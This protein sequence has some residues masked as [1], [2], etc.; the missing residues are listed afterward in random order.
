MESSSKEG[1]PRK[2]RTSQDLVAKKRVG[3]GAKKKSRKGATVASMCKGKKIPEKAV[4]SKSDLGRKHGGMLL[5]VSGQTLV[6][7]SCG[8]KFYRTDKQGRMFDKYGKRIYPEGEVQM[9]E[10]SSEEEETELGVEKLPEN[11]SED[12][13]TPAKGRQRM[14]KQGEGENI[15]E[16]TPGAMREGGDGDGDSG[17]NGDGDDE[18][19]EDDEDVSESEIQVLQAKHEV[20]ELCRQQE[21]AERCTAE[22]LK[23][24]QATKKG[25]R[26]P[27]PKR[28]T[29]K[30][31]KTKKTSKT[32]QRGKKVIA[33]KVPRAPARLMPSTS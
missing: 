20:A 3:G 13:D 22:V 9:V 31:L 8:L 10:E 5:G 26:P 24:R 2:Q 18:Q 30:D 33:T 12:E 7:F 1:T 15:L 17:S 28:K 21:L 4:P 27:S 16:Q 19:E 11:D 25:G 32:T 29:S 6:G 23:I 14:V